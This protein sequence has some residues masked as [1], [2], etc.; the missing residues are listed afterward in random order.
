MPGGPA[1]SNGP[2]STRSGCPEARDTWITDRLGG[3][4]LREPVF[5]PVS[6]TAVIVAPSGLIWAWAM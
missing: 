6:T 1:Q 3:S 2:Y 5:L 4:R